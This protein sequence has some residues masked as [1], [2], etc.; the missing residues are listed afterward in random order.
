[1]ELDEDHPQVLSGGHVLNA[2][3]ACDE[4]RVDNGSIRLNSLE[5]K[6]D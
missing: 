1:M 3:P 4:D 5:G 2:M 6:G